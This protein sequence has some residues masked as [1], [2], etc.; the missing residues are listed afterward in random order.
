MIEKLPNAVYEH[1]AIVAHAQAMGWNPDGSD[2][3][4]DFDDMREYCIE[5]GLTRW[6]PT[7]SLTINYEGS[8]PLKPDDSVYYRLTG[9]GKLALRSKDEGD[10]S[11]ALQKRKKRKQ[12]RGRK[13]TAT[14]DD[15]SVIAELEAGKKDGRWKTDVEFA[16][17]KGR[18]GAWVS[19]VKK[20]LKVRR[21]KKSR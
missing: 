17:Q 1:L 4:P 9:K 2:K 13:P 6:V 11:A 10:G 19:Q 20:R 5:E 18:S 7:G 15:A 3:G 14:E 8:C 21:V 16:R 12:R